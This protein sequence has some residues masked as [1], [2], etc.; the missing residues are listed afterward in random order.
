MALFDFLSAWPAPP[1]FAFGQFCAVPQELSHDVHVLLLVFDH[2][3]A[4]ML[5]KKK[6]MDKAIIM[7]T[8]FQASC[9]TSACVGLFFFF[10]SFG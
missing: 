3:R 10:V 2:M 8:L 5:P 6:R 4:K 1:P 9:V 7:K